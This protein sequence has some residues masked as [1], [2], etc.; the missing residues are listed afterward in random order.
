MKPPLATL[1]AADRVAVT[2][3]YDGVRARRVA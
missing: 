2:G 1:S 3:G